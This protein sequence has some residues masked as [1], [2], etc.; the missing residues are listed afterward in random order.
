M[1]NYKQEQAR[2]NDKRVEAP[3][4]KLVKGTTAASYAAMP[5]TLEES[6]SKITSDSTT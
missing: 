5:C 1:R 3:T 2:T 6:T 4:I